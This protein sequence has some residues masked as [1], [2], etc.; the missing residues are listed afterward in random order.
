M[1]RDASVFEWSSST[2]TVVYYLRRWLRFDGRAV[3]LLP[4]PRLLCSTKTKAAAVNG[5][6]YLGIDR[7]L[8]GSYKT[9]N[10][11]CGFYRS[12]IIIIVVSNETARSEYAGRRSQYLHSCGV[13]GCL[14]FDIVIRC[15][16]RISEWNSEPELHR[17]TGVVRFVCCG[18]YSLL[19]RQNLDRDREKWVEG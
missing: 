15:R 18:L 19:P 6:Q 13:L 5:Y 7:L 4:S 3:F 1:S 12:D 14:F 17:C 9:V 8:V 2:I 10:I 11:G 16:E